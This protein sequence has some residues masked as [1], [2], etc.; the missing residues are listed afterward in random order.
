MEDAGSGVHVRTY[1]LEFPGLPPR[2]NDPR[3]AAEWKLAA[4]PFAS[5]S[6]ANAVASNSSATT[7]RPDPHF[8]DDALRRPVHWPVWRNSPRDAA[9]AFAAPCSGTNDCR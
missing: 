2:T 6:G 3:D 8:V 4:S 7:A 1:R 9:T 5:S